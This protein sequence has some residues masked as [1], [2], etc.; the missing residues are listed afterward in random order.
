MER[1]SV[2]EKR[3]IWHYGYG[4][5]GFTLSMIETAIEVTEDRVPAQATRQLINMRQEV[6]T[7]P[8]ELLPHVCEAIEAVSE[9]HNILLISTGDLIDPMRKLAQSGSD[10]SVICFLAPVTVA[11]RHRGAPERLGRL[12]RHPNHISQEGYHLN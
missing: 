3:N 1:L 11:Q 12:E 9:T 8:I 10:E 7:H 5:K 4:I 6:P 2:E